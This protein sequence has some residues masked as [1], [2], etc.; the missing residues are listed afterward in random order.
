[1][2]NTGLAPILASA[3]CLSSGLPWPCCPDL[4]QNSKCYSGTSHLPGPSALNP[5]PCHQ[6]A[7]GVRKVYTHV[8]T[9]WVERLLRPGFLAPSEGP[10]NVPNARPEGQT[11][12]CER[13]RPPAKSHLLH[14][15]GQVG[16]NQRS[17]HREA[18]GFSLSTTVPGPERESPRVEISAEDRLSVGWRADEA[19]SRQSPS[20]P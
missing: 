3:P 6:T 5:R 11:G 1:M 15:A 19:Q 16:W 10:P 7:L 13:C 4:K 18:L 14:L 9:V 2:E 12:A 8:P 17:P 20:A